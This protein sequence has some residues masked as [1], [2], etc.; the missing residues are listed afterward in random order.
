L[1]YENFDF[2]KLLLRNRLKVLYCTKLAHAEDDKE[3]AH[4][5]EEMKSDPALKP[6]WDQLQKTG[7]GKT[8][9]KCF[10]FSSSY[11]CRAHFEKGGYEH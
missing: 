9:G 8:L 11:N 10:W 7:K 4:I 5:E 6:I 3:K 2:I 1:D